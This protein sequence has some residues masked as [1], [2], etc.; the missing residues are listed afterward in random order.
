M[1]KY[2]GKLAVGYA[3]LFIKREKKEKLE[4]E[5]HS[6]FQR[7]AATVTTMSC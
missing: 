3:Y 7:V 4:S 6:L 5:D 2:V 1:D